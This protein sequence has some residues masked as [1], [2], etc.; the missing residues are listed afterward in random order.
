MLALLLGKEVGQN[1]T[2]PRQELPVF[3]I[4]GALKLE[5]GRNRP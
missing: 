2:L 5:H 1:A 4:D 3:K